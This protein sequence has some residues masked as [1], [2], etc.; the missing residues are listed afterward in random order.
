MKVTFPVAG[1]TVLFY[2]DS[3][4]DRWGHDPVFNF[5]AI[6]SAKHGWKA[7]IH[8][9]PGTGY[10]AGSRNGKI[11]AFPVRAGQLDPTI[12]P[13][14]I[15]L[16]GSINDV[17]IF[18]VDKL[19][20]GATRTIHT[21][22]LKYPT[23]QLVMIGPAPSTWGPSIRRRTFQLGGPSNIADADKVLATLA[24]E[25]G[26]PYVSPTQERWINGRNIEDV[27]SNTD[28]H[29]SDTGQGFLA[30]KIEEAL[31]RLSRDGH[32]ANGEVIE[33]ERGA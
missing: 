6:L 22:R 16:Q 14:L 4:T 17:S 2:G 18:H 12:A 29:P 15:I 5:P 11:P 8:G 26:V 25:S 27:I 28:R 33:S 10:I 7:S 31:L 1:A 30:R 24:E 19:R 23:A 3:W 21:L 20:E 9:G 13:D 32:V